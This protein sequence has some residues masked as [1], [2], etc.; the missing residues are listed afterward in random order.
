[1]SNL[2]RFVDDGK[3]KWSNSRLNE[4]DFVGIES[5]WSTDLFHR[6]QPFYWTLYFQKKLE[7][8]IFI[9]TVFAK[10]LDYFWSCLFMEEDKYLE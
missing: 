9:I 4:C 8:Y 1:M 3:L 6:R 10:Y 2:A 5:N 7:R